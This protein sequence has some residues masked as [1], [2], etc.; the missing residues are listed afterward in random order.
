[1]H[2]GGARLTVVNPGGRTS[3]GPTVGGENNHTP[4]KLLSPDPGEQT[5]T[6]FAIVFEEAR[7]NFLPRSLLVPNLRIL[8]LLH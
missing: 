5:K 4:K 7:A 3:G 1:M 6:I 2:A 8:W